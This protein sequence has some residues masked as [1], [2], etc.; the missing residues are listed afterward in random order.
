V[1]DKADFAEA[2]AADTG[3]LDG[4]SLALESRMR[5]LA[6]QVAA[7]GADTASARQPPQRAAL[8]TRIRGFFGVQ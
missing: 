2:L 6:E 4:L 5:N 7:A 1:V 3:I 8:L